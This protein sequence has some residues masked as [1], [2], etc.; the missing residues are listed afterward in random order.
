MLPPA[1]HRD[2][3]GLERI[4]VPAVLAYA[5]GDAFGVQYE[6]C[7]PPGQEIRQEI[8]EKPGWPRGAVSDDTLLSILTI[9]S[10][11]RGEPEASAL[12]FIEL[13]REAVPRLRGLGPTTRT[14]LGLPVSAEEAGVVGQTNGAMMRTALAGL[15]FA[16]DKRAQRRAWIAA[17]ARATH[18]H[19]RAIACAV[20]LSAAF[21]EAT[22]PRERLDT[23]AIARVIEQEARDFRGSPPE[24]LRSL[25]AAQDWL[26]PAGGVSLDPL[27]TLLAVLWSLRG[28]RS[29]AEVFA[30]A[31]SL[32]GDTDTVAALA[33][34]LFTA[35]HWRDHGFFG[36]EWL[37]DVQWREIPQLIDAAYALLRRRE[38][39]HE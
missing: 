35:W 3:S 33:G 1:F 27:E 8:R 17:S 22:R 39:A 5:A 9:D 6:F 16:P 34:A 30:K 11:A 13:L 10:L 12:C 23:G 26:P 38:A 32:G 31:C 25:A 15:S 18:S 2:P 29:C 20:L 21:S 36:I 4:I 37:E 28:G 19:P 14:A 24:L 7:G